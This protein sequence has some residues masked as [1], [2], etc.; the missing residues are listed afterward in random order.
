MKFSTDNGLSSN[1]GFKSNV[2]NKTEPVK[3]LLEIFDLNKSDFL[4]DLIKPY[5]DFLRIYMYKSCDSGICRTIQFINNS[6]D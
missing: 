5:V 6:F 2:D 4:K 3:D 1:I